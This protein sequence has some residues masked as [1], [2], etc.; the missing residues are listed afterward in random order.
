MARDAALLSWVQQQA[1]PCWVL[2][3]YQW[4]P[5]TLSVGVHQRLDSIAEAIPSAATHGTALQSIVRRPTG[6][7]AIPHGSDISVAFITNAP[8]IVKAPLAERYAALTQPLLMALQQV[9]IAIA[10]YTGTDPTGGVNAY[11]AH[12]LCFASHTP[13]DIK[14]TNGHK[15]AGCAQHVQKNGILQHGA[16]FFPP[17]NIVAYTD[18]CQALNQALLTY[19]Q[20]TQQLLGLVIPQE[21]AIMP[22]NDADPEWQALYANHLSETEAESDY[23]TRELSASFATT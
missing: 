11:A 8:A 3:T 5:T 21:T 17:Q 15:I 19:L 22:F 9:G 12:S 20:Q 4:P 14:D 18:W 23:L 7:R 1:Q 10:G 13:W 16:V 2:H 6:G